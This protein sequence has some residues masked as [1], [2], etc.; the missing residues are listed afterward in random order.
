MKNK[1][2]VKVMSP[3]QGPSIAARMRDVLAL[4][5]EDPSREGLVTTP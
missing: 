2:V 4:L 5:G 3:P 1:A